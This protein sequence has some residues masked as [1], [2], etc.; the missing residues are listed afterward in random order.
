MRAACAVSLSAKLSTS[1]GK[2][3]IDDAGRQHVE[4]DGDEDE[5]GRRAA[6]PARRSHYR[7]P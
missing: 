1:F 3:G 7:L 6:R 2:I 5:S 4:Q